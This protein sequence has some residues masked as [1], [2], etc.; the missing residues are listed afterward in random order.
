MKINFFITSCRVYLDFE[1]QIL[2]YYNRL[3]INLLNII[4][5]VR[6][7]ENSAGVRRFL[8]GEALNFLDLFGPF[9]GNAKKDIA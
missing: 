8:C 2:S 9:W 4:S 5:L 1:G 3:I 6:W 7:P